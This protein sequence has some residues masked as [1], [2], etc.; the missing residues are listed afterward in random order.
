MDPDQWRVPA[1]V[2]HTTGSFHSNRKDK[3][4]LREVVRGDGKALHGQ[5]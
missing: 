3:K 4:C 2:A 5:G 1:D